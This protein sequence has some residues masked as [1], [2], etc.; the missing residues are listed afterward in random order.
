MAETFGKPETLEEDYSR[1]LAQDIYTIGKLSVDASVRREKFAQ[2]VL[3]PGDAAAL[4]ALFHTAM[5][6]PIEARAAIAEARKSSPTSPESDLAEA[7]LLSSEEKREDARAAIARAVASG[8]TNAHAYYELARLQWTADADAPALAEREKLLTRATALNPNSALSFALLAETRSMQGA[9]NPALELAARAIKLDP[10]EPDYRLT[11]ARILFRMGARPDAL[12][13]AAA[14]L[15]L[16][17]DEDDRQRAR[18]LQQTI[19][20]QKP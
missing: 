14:A 1:Y 4:L 10:T 18:E 13:A 11:A 20:R 12:K 16:A 3:P 15:S 17:R 2:R 8:S 6:R 7:L 9:N 19:E 5:Q